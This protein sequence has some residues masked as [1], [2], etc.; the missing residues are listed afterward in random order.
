MSQSALRVAE[1]ERLQL[2]GSRSRI[3][4]MECRL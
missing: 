4:A 2:V 1:N 3:L